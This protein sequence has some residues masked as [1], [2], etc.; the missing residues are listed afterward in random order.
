ML[1][2]ANDVI[3]LKVITLETGKEVAK[4]QDVVYDP[5][6]NMVKALVIDEGGWFS[7]AKVILFE[8][9]KSIGE[10]AVI[11]ESEEKVRTA[12]EV[13]SRVANIAREEQNLTKTK[14][15]TEEGD[16]LGSVSDI[17]FDSKTGKV[18]EF[19][20]SQGAQNLASGK[21]TIRVNNII[22]VGED[23]TIVSGVSKQVVEQQAQQ[24]GIQG[25]IK[26]ATETVKEKVPQYMEQAREKAE[27]LTGKAKEKGEEAKEKVQEGAKGLEEEAKET[28]QKAEVRERE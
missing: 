26:K 21:K 17:I 4:V 6:D 7:D 18:E 11:I 16:E 27:E 20:V 24:Q 28:A 25:A 3:G 19:E 1:I 8:D 5:R 9:I 15:I 13:S 12:S 22:T 23:A 14:I 2:K 10:D